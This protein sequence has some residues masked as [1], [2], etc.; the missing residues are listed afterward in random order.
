MES[1]G[2]FGFAAIVSYVLVWIAKHLDISFNWWD[3]AIIILGSS[4]LASIPDIDIRLR[5]FGVKHRGFTHTVWFALVLAIPIYVGLDYLAEK[6]FQFP[7]S[8]HTASLIVVLAVLTH[9]LAD[10]LNYHKIRPLA[11]LSNAAVSLRLF[12]SSNMFANAGFFLIGSA[13][14]AAYF[15]GIIDNGEAVQAAVLASF[16]VAVLASFLERIRGK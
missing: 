7:I 4:F 11:P 10:I 8:P 1:S 6:G 13:I 3:G 16:M 12:H 14:I 5:Y 15:Y 9:I 2:H